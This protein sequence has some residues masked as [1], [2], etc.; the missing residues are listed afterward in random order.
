MHNDNH[1]KMAAAARQSYRVES[2]T[3]L[4]KKFAG[5]NTKN[6]HR[7]HK[8]PPLNP[9]LSQ[10]NSVYP[11]IQYFSKI[12]HDSK[13]VTSLGDDDKQHLSSVIRGQVHTNV[14]S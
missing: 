6:H 5:L 11:T 12:R 4:V 3:Q 9:A 13:A 14:S 8:R 1:D 10:T 7:V 2:S